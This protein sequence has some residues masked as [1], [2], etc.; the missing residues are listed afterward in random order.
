MVKQY[1]PAHP[2]FGVVDEGEGEGA[3]ERRQRLEEPTWT[4]RARND[5]LLE[6][7]CW[8]VSAHLS[9]PAT[10]RRADRLRPQ[11]V[12]EQAHGASS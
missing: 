9:Q 8:I 1:G 11:S 6:V 12:S 3:L 10:N 4:H 2:A 5:A 7:R